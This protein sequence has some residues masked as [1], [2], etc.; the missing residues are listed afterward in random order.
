M[1]AASTMGYLQ[2]IDVRDGKTLK[3]F[4]GHAAPI[5]DFVEVKALEIIVTAGDD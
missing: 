5:N 4:R 2:L 3:T 1:Y